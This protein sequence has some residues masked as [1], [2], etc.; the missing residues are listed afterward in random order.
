MMTCI[1]PLQLIEVIRDFLSFD[2]PSDT[3]GGTQAGLI[4]T[5]LE[6]KKLKLGLVMG[7][8]YSHATHRWLG[9]DSNPGL[10]GTKPGALPTLSLWELLTA[11]QIIIII[12]IIILILVII[13]VIICSSHIK[14]SEHDLI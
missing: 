12:L 5:V 9:Q 8:A 7:F 2:P 1:G 3:V 10:P 13:A 4:I 14:N 11:L 6:L